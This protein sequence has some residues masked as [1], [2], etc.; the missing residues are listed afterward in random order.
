MKTNGKYLSDNWYFS[1]P[2]KPVRQIGL[3]AQKHEARF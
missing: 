2:Q 3:W 1:L